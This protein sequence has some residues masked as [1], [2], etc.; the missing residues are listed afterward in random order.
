MSTL[1][2]VRHAQASFLAD[3]YDQLSELGR[4]QARQ[5]GR[6]F[7]ATGPSFDAVLVGPRRRQRQTAELLAEVLPG[8]PEQ[9]ELGELDEYPADEVLRAR[10]PSLAEE[11]P[12]LFAEL[13]NAPEASVRGRA[14][15]RLLQRALAA[16]AEAGDRRAHEH[17][18]WSDFQA[19]VARALER[20]TAGAGR[21]RRVLAVSSAGTIGA[22][23]GQVL[24]VRAEVCLE[25][26]W[27]LNNASVCEIVFSPGRA[28]LSRFNAVSHLP[29]TA[30]LTRR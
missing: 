16:W 12:A 29:D 18:S 7:L 4:E 13:T 17:E 3:D 15:E 27:M 25:L 9:G 20:C 28:N 8:L 19:R 5:L 14:L 26:G 24:G 22:M 11:H 2:L 1:Y 23:V 21:G 6:W 10:L 30:Q